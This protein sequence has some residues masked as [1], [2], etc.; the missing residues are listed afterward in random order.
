MTPDLQVRL[1]RVLEERVVRPVGSS[2]TEKVDVRVV[3][4]THRNLGQLVAAG[5]FRPDLLYR[6]NV[7]ELVLPPLRERTGD[8]PLLVA[9]LLEVAATKARKPVPRLGSGA[10]EAL[11]RYPWPGNVRELGNVLE[12]GVVHG[13]DPIELEHLGL[14]AA[15]RSAA[16]PLRAYKDRD[17]AL[18]AEAMRLAQGNKSEAA[19]ILGVSRKTFYRK[20]DLDDRR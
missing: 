1:L 3:A 14:P 11:E 7:L 10:L 17:P 8:L 9:H 6:L 18:V 16:P 4:A 19:R 13:K 5:R 15:A 20:F 12:R 2:R